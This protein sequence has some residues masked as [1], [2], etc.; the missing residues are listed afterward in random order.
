M[1]PSPPLR[2]F[3]PS[4]RCIDDSTMLKRGIV[5][6]SIS[7]EVEAIQFVSQHT[8][9][10]VPQIIYHGVDDSGFGYFTMKLVP[11]KSIRTMWHHIDETQRI[12]I[13]A[14]LKDHINQLRSLKQ[15][16]P[17]WIGSC[18]H[19]PAL[20]QRINNGVPFGPL[21]NERAFNDLLLGDLEEHHPES[22]K[23]Y[24][25]SLGEDHEIVFTHGD[26]SG[27]NIFMANGRVAAILDWET[28]GGMP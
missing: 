27:E 2:Q 12:S 8:N 6:S 11:G 1:H 28:A 22:A 20:D 21:D 23:V 17:A 14:D 24:R 7:R 15:P 13:I 10:P 19:G 3:P 16:D 5:V 9:I 4:V 18:S 26:L 25:S